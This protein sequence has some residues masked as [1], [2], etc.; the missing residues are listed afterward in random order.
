M[1]LLI[2][3]LYPAPSKLA[4]TFAF[5]QKINILNPLS[6]NTEIISHNPY[7]FLFHPSDDTQASIAA[8]FVKDHIDK[9]KKSLII[10]GSRQADSIAA[11]KYRDL[12]MELVMGVIMMDPIPTVDSEEVAKFISDNLYE[13]FTPLPGDDVL[14]TT[15]EDEDEQKQEEGIFVPRSDLAHVF[16]AST[17]ELVVA[18]VI[19]TLDNIGA[20]ISIMGNDRWLQSRYV[21]FQQL[22]RLQVYMLAPGYLDYQSDNYKN[23]RKEYQ[24]TF[25]SIPNSYSFIGYDLM[26]FFGKLLNQGGTYFQHEL[27]KNDFYP[28][29]LFQ[30][31]NYQQNNDNAHIPIVHFKDGVL[32]Q[33]N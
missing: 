24:R 25:G 6:S 33:A 15:A 5:D 29:Y 26:L 27:R 12:L 22:E 19:G 11:F 13:I 21:D 18:N 17:N 1:D 16:V 10:Y 2:G 23:F 3:P 14:M 31:Y 32:K 28:G 30:G 20:D 9:N 7:S 8:G 4:Y